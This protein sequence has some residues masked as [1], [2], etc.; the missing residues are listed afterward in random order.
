MSLLRKYGITRW[1]VERR[2]S[3]VRRMTSPF[4]IELRR[5]GLAR[6]AEATPREINLVKKYSAYTMT[7]ELAR[8]SLL[9]AVRYVDERRIPGD[10]VECGVWRGGNLM[11]VKDYRQPTPIP[12]RLFLYDTFAGM[13]QPTA[14]DV[15][16]HGESA[17]HIHRRRQ[18]DGYN[19]WAYAS[20]EDVT[21]A[22]RDHG[23][24]DDQVIFQRGPV[25]STLLNDGLPEVISIL[26]LDT[27]WYEST[28]IEL[29]VLFP[30]LAPGGVLIIDDYGSWAGSRKATDEYFS[31]SPL[32]LI[33]VDDGCRIAI[34]A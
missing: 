3:V 4:E 27:D 33:P 15:G 18:R 1:L 7:S 14:D 17:I 30:R 5:G 13:T 11:M 26:R 22:F 19:A 32:L 21:R 29:E 8:W 25:E 24:L 9:R 16:A 12:R 28:R 6:L 34:K 2:R 31:G 20:L 23:L 10:I